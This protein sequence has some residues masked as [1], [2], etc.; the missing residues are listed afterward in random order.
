[1]N[2]AVLTEDTEVDGDMTSSTKPEVHNVTQ[3]RRRRTEPRPQATCTKNLVTFGR[4]RRI[5]FASDASADRQTDILLAIR[6]QY[7]CNEDISAT[8]C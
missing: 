6:S 3:H 8:A 5:L 4:N 1:M 7:L 2:R